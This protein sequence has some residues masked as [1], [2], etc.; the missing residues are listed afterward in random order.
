MKKNILYVL[1]IFFLFFTLSCLCA[2]VSD[3]QKK[4]LK[5]NVQDK[6][7]AVKESSASDAYMLAEQGIGFVLETRPLIGADRDLSALAVA[8]ILKL[9]REDSALADNFPDINSQLVQIFNLFEDETVRIAVLDKFEYTA[10]LKDFSQAVGLLNSYLETPE[11]KFRNS[12]VT[13]KAV[14][15]IGKIGDGDSFRIIY[16]AWREDRFP[17]FRKQTEDSL[18]LLSAAHISDT[19]RVISM[20]NLDDIGDFFELINES[21]EISQEFKAEIA[22]NVLS[23]I[24]H[25]AEDNTESLRGSVKLQLSAIKAI[26]DA[27]WTRAAGL[28]VR[29]FGVAAGE[30]ENNSL[31]EEQFIQVIR[32]VTELS[33][34]DCAQALSAYLAEMNSKTEKNQVSAQEVV[35]AII[36]SL[37]ELG[38]KT[39][40][41]NLLYVTYLNYPEAV[42]SAAR[43][44]LAKLKWQ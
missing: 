6:T 23:M 20:S 14:S 5:G 32:C 33:S 1:S 13:G 12:S 27:N 30:Y 37:G 9:P 4:F 17:S 15:T 29:Y 3:I 41:D 38:D 25:N 21:S 43:D 40:F 19:I 18:I 34:P 24:I 22:E 16:S 44:S 39:A 31:S 36:N 26:A 7:A 10:A 42:K 11:E 8:S 2:E 28:A 35:L